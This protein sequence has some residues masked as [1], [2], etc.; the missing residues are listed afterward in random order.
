VTPT[1][2]AGEITREDVV[3][4]ASQGTLFR[5]IRTPAWGSDREGEFP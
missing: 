4:Q 3:R 5:N 1:G 2:L